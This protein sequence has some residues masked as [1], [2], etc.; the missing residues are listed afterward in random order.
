MFQSLHLDIRRPL[1]SSRRFQRLSTIRVLFQSPMFH[2]PASIIPERNGPD[3]NEQYGQSYGHS[4]D[5][6]HRICRKSI[7]PRAIIISRTS[8]R[9][10]PSIGLYWGIHSILTPNRLHLDSLIVDD[11]VI[12]IRNRLTLSGAIIS[13]VCDRVTI[14]SDDRRVIAVECAS[15]ND[16]RTDSKCD[17]SINALV[18]LGDNGS[19]QCVISRGTR[20][21]ITFKVL[22]SQI[23]GDD[24]GRRRIAV[25]IGCE[26]IPDDLGF[27]RIAVVANRCAV[28]GRFNASSQRHRNSTRQSVIVQCGVCTSLFMKRRGY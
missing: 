22:R 24:G 18:I 7:A 28:E 4:N 10:N 3:H 2:F 25:C 14:A 26:H 13:S 1:T 6:G 12:F 20:I 16:I 11:A 17:C 15:I 23:R 9:F 5:R 27:V 8:H 21:A 19:V